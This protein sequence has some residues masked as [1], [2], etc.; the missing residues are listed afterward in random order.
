M[1]SFF[2]Y[3][4]FSL[5][6]ISDE[7]ISEENKKV[8]LK[9]GDFLPDT[10]AHFVF[11][12][13]K[14]LFET[15][16]NLDIAVSTSNN[17]NNCNN[18]SG[19]FSFNGILNEVN[20][21]NEWHRL[22][23]LSK[24]WSKADSSLQHLLEVL[25]LEFD[26][27]S[28]VK[29]DFIPSTF[30]GIESKPNFQ[31]KNQLFERLD[32]FN[33][34]IQILSG[35]ETNPKFFSY[36][37]YLSERIENKL[38]IFQVGLMLS[39][40]NTP[41]RICIKQLLLKDIIVLI[42]EICFNTDLASEAINTINTYGKFFDHFVLALDI[43]E[44]TILKIG[45]ECYFNNKTQPSKEPRWELVLSALCENGYCNELTKKLI[46]NFPKKNVRDIK[47][48]FHSP[49]GNPEFYAQGL[50]HLKLSIPANK[51]AFA[52]IYFWAG[53]KF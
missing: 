33:L 39:R 45:I 31:N 14:R 34:G 50:H 8:V 26:F 40:R 21:E 53:Y 22:H 23:N 52:K 44:D 30:L 28:L 20:K 2:K 10:F 15:E 37:K 19:I 27:D 49:I 25:C 9:L 7:L 17:L 1:D 11:G 51:A 48:F 12:F 47:L 18:F 29:N 4:R 41:I 6:N 24:E 43:L 5:Q 16:G 42:N 38:F 13:E 46:L 36:M 3:L 32:V 35:E